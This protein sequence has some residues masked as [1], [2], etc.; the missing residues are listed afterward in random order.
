MTGRSSNLFKTSSTSH[1]GIPFGTLRERTTTPFG[2]IRWSGTSAWLLNLFFELL[3]NA[4]PQPSFLPA[5]SRHSLA[6]SRVTNSLNLVLELEELTTYCR[7]GDALLGAM[8]NHITK[9]MSHYRGQ[10][11]AWDV[12]N[13]A[14]NDDG[15]LGA[16]PFL[17]EIGPS[18]IRIAFETARLADPHTKL[19]IVRPFIITSRRTA[20]E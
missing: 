11:Y 20:N 6:I 14:F 4:E 7:A 10:I 13:E 1:P 9:V 15:T 2:A 12:V 16:S 19:Y 3:S 5:N 17:S 8:K 18:Y